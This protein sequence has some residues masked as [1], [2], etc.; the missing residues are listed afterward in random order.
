LFL[1]YKGKSLEDYQQALLQPGKEL[2]WFPC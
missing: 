2:P 1:S